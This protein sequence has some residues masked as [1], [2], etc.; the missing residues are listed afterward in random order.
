M[1]IKTYHQDGGAQE[2]ELFGI[3]GGVVTSRA[4]HNRLGMAVVSDPGDVWLVE[5]DKG[6]RPTG[7]ALLH[8]LK[9]KAAVHVRFLTALD[10]TDIACQQRLLDAVTALAKKDGVLQLHTNDRR[11]V[12]I[13]GDNGF[14]AVAGQRRGEFVRWEREIGASK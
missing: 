13:W 10:A 5:T 1:A 7:F 3:L 12:G 14:T 11:D 9:S 4:L 2:R 8:P 6:G